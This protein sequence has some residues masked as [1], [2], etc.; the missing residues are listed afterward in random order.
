MDRINKDLIPQLVDLNYDVEDYPKIEFTGITEVDVSSL[1]TA[2]QTLINSGGIKSL[3]ND[4]MFFR[5]IMDLPELTAEEVAKREQQEQENISRGLNP[6]GSPIPI[7]QPDKTHPPD[8][9]LDPNAP[10]NKKDK[11]STG[12]GGNVKE[13]DVVQ[14]AEMTEQFN[15][16]KKK[17]SL[18]EDLV[19]NRIETKLAKM[20]TPQ[21]WVFVNQM[22][23]KI[24]RLESKPQTSRFFFTLKKVLTIKKDEM[25]RMIFRDNNDFEGW[26]KITMAEKKVDL[27]GIQDMMSSLEDEL[28]TKTNDYLSGVKEDYIKRLAAFLHADDIVGAGALEMSLQ[29]EYRDIVKSIMMKAYVYG[30]TNASKEIGTDTPSNPQDILDI[31]NVAAD[32]IAK[33]HFQDLTSQAKL[34]MTEQLAKS[35][36]AAQVVG[37]VDKALSDVID[38]LT[39]NTAR[40]VVAG[41]L[42]QG[43]MTTFQ[44]NLENVYAAQRSEILD[45]RTCAYCLSLD[46]R[47]VSKD[48]PFFQNTIFHSGCRGIW[49]LIMNEEVDKPDISGIPQSL[50]NRF[51]GAINELSQ[52]KKPL[53]KK[54]SLASKFLNGL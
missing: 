49:V 48:D 9:N 15:S 4:E 14:E 1:A 3:E 23:R 22:L 26:R 28:I 2:Y 19:K 34:V 39:G 20:T 51:G 32:N 13:Q 10:P 46:G 33:S 25:Q 11:Q 12:G 8:A 54:D 7:I 43:R 36:S 30:K 29:N 24:E 31:I 40:I 18:S 52:P 27:G 6:D 53:V 50:R 21:R 41:S 42:N 44:D 35:M 47:I 17:R 45:L 16:F 5:D 38:S 37:M